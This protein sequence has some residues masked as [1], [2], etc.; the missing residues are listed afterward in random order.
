MKMKIMQIE[1]K[2]YLSRERGMRPAEFL[3]KSSGN[4]GYI[5]LSKNVSVP[6]ELIGKRVQFR[7]EVMEN[8]PA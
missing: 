2:I 1:G 3:V 8:E 7:I 6:K 4:A 5:I